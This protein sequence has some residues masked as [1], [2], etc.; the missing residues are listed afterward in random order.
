M[1]KSSN[2]IEIEAVQT[3]AQMTRFIRVPA[4]LQSGDPMFVPQ[5]E[6]ER[7]EAFSPK[8]NPFFAHAKT[9][10]WIATRNGRDVGR[11]SAQIDKLAPSQINDQAGHF[12]L[13]VGEDDAVVFASLFAT[14]EAWLRERGCKKVLGPFN[15][16]INE[17]TGLLVDGFDTPPMLLM[18]HDAPYFGKRIEALGYRKARDMLAYLYDIRPPLTTAL[19]RM[20][21]RPQ[22]RLRVRPMDMKNYLRDINI[23][24]DIYN[25][26][27]SENW[28]FVP[29]TEAEV[30]HLAKALKPLLDPQ[31]VQFVEWDGKAVGFGVTLPNLNEAIRDMGGKLF[32]FN[33]IKLLWRL[34]V[35][36]VKT[37]RVPLMGVRRQLEG[38]S[39][40]LV[41]YLIISAMRKR[42]LER[43]FEHIE[44]S[45][46]LEDNKPMRGMIE[47]LGGRAYKTYRVY[48]K[49]L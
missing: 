27:W 46:I 5:L 19:Q 7:A 4:A 1:S 28:G 44:L 22:T 8:I 2:L 17:E 41:P 49:A 37:G 38:L 26:A 43:G 34:K 48:E 9:Q 42:G 14:A 10:F 15:L 47:S 13:I 29:Y 33:F 32:P 36:G 31:L 24:T 21:D 6:M 39:A 40:S 35:S 16:S 23:I 20:I 11:I 18:G 12:G 45:W 30:D 25:D 3:K